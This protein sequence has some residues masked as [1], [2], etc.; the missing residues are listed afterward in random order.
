[1]FL[2]FYLCASSL[3]QYSFECSWLNRVLLLLLLA[4]CC[5]LLLAACGC[6]WLLVAAC[7]CCCCRC[8]S[9]PSPHRDSMARAYYDCM[10]AMFC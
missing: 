4:A 5:W 7:G 10:C 1:M 9:R 3:F 8:W 2:V 6:L